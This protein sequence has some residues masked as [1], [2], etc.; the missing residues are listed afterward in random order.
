MAPNAGY[1]TQNL[2]HSCAHM[3]FSLKISG[4]SGISMYS[5]YLVLLDFKIMCGISKIADCLGKCNRRTSKTSFKL[6]ELFLDSI[7]NILGAE[8]IW[9]NNSRSS[10]KFLN[11]YRARSSSRKFEKKMWKNCL[12]KSRNLWEALYG[13]GRSVNCNKLILLTYLQFSAHL[14]SSAT[15]PEWI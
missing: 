2:F 10:D 11:S 12:E 15:S 3:I 14:L 8:S 5:W 9:E 4:R 13:F 6:L 1:E 7:L